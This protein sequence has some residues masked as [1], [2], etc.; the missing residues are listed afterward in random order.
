[1]T[2]IRRAVLDAVKLWLDTPYQHQA[3]QRGAGCDCL[4][5]I[6]G[7]YRDIY[8]GEPI[9]PPPYTPDWAEISK[10][11]TLLNAAR[12]WLEEIPISRTLPGDVVMFRMRP[13]S[14]C[15][16]LGI[17]SAPHII[18]HAYWGRSVVESH[19]VPYWRKRWE[20]S[21]AFPQF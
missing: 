14:P 19:M 17:L 5:L 10:E 13:D 2:E 12:D 1:M 21:F 16:H 8:G 3:A 20:Y 18:T 7:V 11:E 4:G 15:K 9:V 6:R